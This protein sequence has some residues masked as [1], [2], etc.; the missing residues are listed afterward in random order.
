MEALP[1]EGYPLFSSKPYASYV[2]LP[3]L[4]LA[5]V[6]YAIAIHLRFPSEVF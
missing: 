5:F 4:E 1:P 6:E 3:M 2:F